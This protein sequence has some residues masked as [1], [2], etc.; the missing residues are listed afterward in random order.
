MEVPSA[1]PGRVNSSVLPT[2]QIF[3]EPAAKEIAWKSGGKDLVT[4]D[5]GWSDFGYV[6]IMYPADLL[7]I[8]LRIERKLLE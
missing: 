6:G 3:V 2:V 4:R 8:I 7:H 1:L 5:S